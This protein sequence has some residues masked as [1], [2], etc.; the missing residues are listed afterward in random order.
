M[1][2]RSIGMAIK[3]DKTYREP[4]L[5]EIATKISDILQDIRF[6][7]IEITIHEGK[8][9]QIERKEKLRFDNK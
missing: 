8:V 1:A 4:R 9:V 2:F 3:L 7:S 6:G 5:S